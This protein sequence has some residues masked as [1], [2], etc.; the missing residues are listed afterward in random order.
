MRGR[1]PSCVRTSKPRPYKDEKQILRP[2]EASGTQTAR[3]VAPQNDKHYSV[4]AA[5]DW[6]ERMRHTA[7]SK[8]RQQ[9]IGGGAS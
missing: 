1:G 7:K 2:A 9:I 6:L 8:Q 3:R 4:G 5:V